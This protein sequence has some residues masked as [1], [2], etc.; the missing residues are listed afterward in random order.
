VPLPRRLNHASRSDI[1]AALLCSH[2][3]GEFRALIEFGG[4]PDHSTRTVVERWLTE[5]RT[6]ARV[7]AEGGGLV[8]RDFACAGLAAVVGVDCAAFVQIGD[9]AIVV[10]L[11]S[12]PDACAWVFRPQRGEYENTTRFAT[13]AVALEEAEAAGCAVAWSRV[14][15]AGL[16]IPTRVLPYGMFGG[17]GGHLGIL[18]SPSRCASGAQQHAHGRAT[19]PG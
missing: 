15:T 7:R 8:P 4:C 5:F 6:E 11:G 16:V 13:D 12:V 9:G 1:G 17:V 19:N 18:G 14:T 3:V 2:V 10:S